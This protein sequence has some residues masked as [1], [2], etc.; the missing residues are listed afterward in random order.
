MRKEEKIRNEEVFSIKTAE[1]CK[2][3]LAL[4]LI[5]IILCSTVAW[6]FSSAGGRIKIQNVLFNSRGAAISAELYYPYGTSD[7]DKLPAIVL[8]HG[9]G[10]T[11]N[12]YRGIAEELA[13]RGFVV[14]NT[15]TYGAGLSDMP[16]YDEADLGIEQ[17]IKNYVYRSSPCGYLDAVDY[18]R[19]LKFVDTTRIGLAG[20]SAG[21]IK[22]GNAAMMDC[23]YLSLN[24][25]FVNIL[26]EEFGEEFTGEEIYI[27]ADI[28]AAERLDEEELRLYEMLK[29]NCSNQYASKIKSLILIG[30]TMSG[31]L[32][33]QTVTVAGHEVTRACNTNIAVVGGWYDSN[34]AMSESQNVAVYQPE[35]MQNKQ[36]YILNQQ[37]S[38]SY[39]IGALGEISILEDDTLARAIDDRQTRLVVYNSETRSQNY[40]SHTTASEVV[41]V[42]EQTLAY[43]WGDLGST[44]AR[45]IDSSSGIYKW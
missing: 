33:N 17:G 8:A 2:R 45:P 28:L 32:D 27:D 1:D 16:L 10:M 38:S 3:M 25:A 11:Y 24:D 18:I 21:G 13:R 22:S 20:H 44:D 40:F 39:S 19:T 23:G 9:G 29:E 43:N 26:Y 5:L 15:N 35:G 30:I 4:M 37:E 41:K 34:A 31:A 7:D 42:F 12:G 14:L 6:C 36:W